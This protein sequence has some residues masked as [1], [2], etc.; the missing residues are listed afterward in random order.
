MSTTRQLKGITPILQSLLI[1]QI[2]DVMTAFNGFDYVAAW[3]ALDVL[4][5]SSPPKVQD[6]KN[7]TKPDKP[8]YNQPSPYEEVEDIRT[9]LNRI[10][11]SSS[12]NVVLARV[13]QSSEAMNLLRAK[14]KPLFR[15]VMRLLYDG[16]YL[17]HHR[18][19]AV[20]KEIGY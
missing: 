5:L 7:E 2:K 19:F 8:D 14:L 1:D 9:R 11:K 13:R 18:E 12:V 15:R 3:G 16:G 17:E 10:T 4:V 6:H 20:G